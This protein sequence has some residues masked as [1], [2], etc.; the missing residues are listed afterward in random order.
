MLSLYSGGKPRELIRRTKRRMTS[1][2][3][4]QQWDSDVVV[5]KSGGPE[6]VMLVY[7]PSKARLAHCMPQVLKVTN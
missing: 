2:C 5:R 7:I 3:L 6:S 4:G 1:G